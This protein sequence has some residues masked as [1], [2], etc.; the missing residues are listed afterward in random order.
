MPYLDS[1]SQGCSLP[2]ASGVDTGMADGQRQLVDGLPSVGC[3]SGGPLPRE[4]EADLDQTS[5]LKKVRIRSVN[6]WQVTAS[7]A[8]I[9]DCLDIGLI[10]QCVVDGNESGNWLPRNSCFNRVED[11]ACKFGRAGH[12]R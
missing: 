8:E 9:V 11:L 12:R 4:K 10:N 2:S 7:E 3:P 1:E 5:A 6:A